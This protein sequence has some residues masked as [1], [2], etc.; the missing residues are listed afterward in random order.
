MNI[1]IYTFI[2]VIDLTSLDESSLLSSK[3][4]SHKTIYKDNSILSKYQA[5]PKSM[6]KSKK[7]RNR[8]PITLKE[9]SFLFI[10]RKKRKEE[11][12][13]SARHTPSTSTPSFQLCEFAL[14]LA[15]L[16][17]LNGSELWNSSNKSSDYKK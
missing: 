4:K 9:R 12:G 11:E 10:Y 7:E 17:L 8:S 14:S 1:R 15:S 5:Y 2:F 16:A 13:A 3:T 6:L